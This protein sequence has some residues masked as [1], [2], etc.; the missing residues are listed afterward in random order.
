[1]TDQNSLIY[2]TVDLFLYDLRDGLGQDEEKINLNRK[3]FW[4]KIYGTNL[5]HQ[6]LED[7]KQAEKESADYIE[8]LGSDRFEYFEKPLNGYF[9][10][11]QMGDTYALQVD[12][13]GDDDP[14]SKFTVKHVSYLNKIKENI[15]VYIKN[16]Q[17]KIG[18]TWLIWGK[19]SAEK[20]DLEQTAKDCYKQFYDKLS[21][22]KQ[23][24]EQAVK[25]SDKQLKLAPKQNW[26]K[27]LKGKG[28]IL[29]ATVFELWR[30]PSDWKDLSENYHLLICIFPYE[31]S[32]DSILKFMPKLYPQLIHLFRYRNKI[33]WAY[34]QSR[35]FK[36]NLKQDSKLVQEIVSTISA[37]VN[38]LKPDLNKLQES[39]VI[40]SKIILSHTKNLSYLDDQRRN[41]KINIANYEKRL[42]AIEKLYSDSNLEFLEEFSEF[43]SE[44]YL[45]QVETN[46]A[47]FSPEL[48]LLENS[49]K[50]IEGIVEIEQTKSDRNL[51]NTITAV[52]IGLATTEVTSAVL[53]SQVPQPKEDSS[54]S[55]ASAAVWSILAGV[56]AIGLA[57]IILRAARSHH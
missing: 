24:L 40:N 39:L 55:P 44:K 14:I 56:F 46:G 10:P 4:E 26:E 33:L 42:K 37:Q 17:G 1:M 54:F 41:I 25:D 2:P 30:L 43:A 6:R 13:S 29:D 31:E 32:I 52:G 36:D 8:L 47:N 12:C 51:D 18:Q 20:Q 16:S 21:T 9:Y 28:K 45:I 5:E 7:L 34:S 22:E 11:V 53:V 27:D 49:M 15:L 19:L 57:L 3:Q 35:Q 50:T 38:T 23:N 48:T